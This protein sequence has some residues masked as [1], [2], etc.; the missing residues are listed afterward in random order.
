MFLYFEIKPLNAN[1]NRPF[2]KECI[3]WENKR[4]DYIFW[5][6]W[7]AAIT[8]PVWVSDIIYNGCVIA[9]I[10]FLE[11][12]AASYNLNSWQT[13][14][15]YSGTEYPSNVKI[16]FCL[17]LKNNIIMAIFVSSIFSMASD[18]LIASARHWLTLMIR[19]N[20]RSTELARVW[21]IAQTFKPLYFEFF[22]AMYILSG[23]CSG[24]FFWI[25]SCVP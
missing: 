7:L 5:P 12:L 9:C 18:T 16:R 2:G 23:R 21:S 13:R 1:F 20:Q 6:C 17:F 3:T 10:V 19:L 4:T 15:N 14:G 22:Q 24:S 8:S 25:R 11:I